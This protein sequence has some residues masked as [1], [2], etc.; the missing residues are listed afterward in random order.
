M[1]HP[2]VCR[3]LDTT[4]RLN[5]MITLL[6]EMFYQASYYYRELGSNKIIFKI[7]V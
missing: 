3:E 2:W 7:M 4:E 6:A 1:L 5:N